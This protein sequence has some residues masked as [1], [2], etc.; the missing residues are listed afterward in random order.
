MSERSEG[1]DMPELLPGDLRAPG[2]T[3][4]APTARTLTRE[5]MELGLEPHIV[6]TAV[7]IFGVMAADAGG[8]V[9]V[10]V[11]GTP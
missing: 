10:R 4:P 7:Q 2:R 3:I 6:A 9:K 11:D 5:L 8:G 1:M